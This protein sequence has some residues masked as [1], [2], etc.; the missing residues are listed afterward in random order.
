MAKKMQIVEIKDTTETPV[1]TPDGVHFAAYKVVHGIPERKLVANRWR[2]IKEFNLLKRRGD[3]GNTRKLS[4]G[5][6]DKYVENL[7]QT[8]PSKKV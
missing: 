5:T 6:F 2:F 4:E 1:V 7:K 3:A 8:A